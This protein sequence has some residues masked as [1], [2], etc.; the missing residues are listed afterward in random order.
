M[1]D[2]TLP[3]WCCWPG[4]RTLAES[5]SMPLCEH[6][7]QFVG[8]RFMAE[9]SVL[10]GE[11]DA[12]A[13]E[14]RRAENAERERQLRAEREAASVVY[15]VRIGDHVKIGYTQD[16]HRRLGDLRLDPDAV[17]AVEPGG[18]DLERCRHLQFADER[19]GRRENFNPSRRLLA[20]IESLRQRHGQPAA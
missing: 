15:Y 18:P 1:W 5:G 7:F 12:D 3:R 4:C 6:H 2:R 14:Q 17:M 11:F 20:H 8:I 19:V 16:L 13:R 9:R 10:S